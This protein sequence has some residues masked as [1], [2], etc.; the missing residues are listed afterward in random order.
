MN[1]TF[2]YPR[3]AQLGGTKGFKKQN[4]KEKYQRERKA[5]FRPTSN[6]FKAKGHQLRLG[7]TQRVDRESKCKISNLKESRDRNKTKIKPKIN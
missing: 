6:T 5:S 7:S 1:K 3:G 4:V 2:T